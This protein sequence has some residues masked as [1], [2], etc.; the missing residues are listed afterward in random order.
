M[1]STMLYSM[2]TSWASAVGRASLKMS[3]VSGAVP[4]RWSAEEADASCLFASMAVLLLC[5][6]M[7]CVQINVQFYRA[8]V[9]AQNLVVD[10]GS[11]D[12]VRHPFRHQEIVDPPAGVPCPRPEAV[13]PPAVF[14]LVGVQQPEAVRKARLQQGGHLGPLLVGK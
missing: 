3:G 4:S 12:L 6:S 8:V 5:S 9:G 2:F 13:A 14:Y 10:L 7:L 1:R 11:A